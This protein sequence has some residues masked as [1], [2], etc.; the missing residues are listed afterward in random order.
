MIQPKIFCP[1]ETSRDSQKEHLHLECQLQPHRLRVLALALLNLQCCEP[2]ETHSARSH[3]ACDLLITQSKSGILL[4]QNRGR[5]VLRTGRDGTM[6]Q[7]AHYLVESTLATLEAVYVQAETVHWQSSTGEDPPQDWE[8][9][10]QVQRVQAEEVAEIAHALFIHK[11]TTAIAHYR[12]SQSHLGVVLTRG[13]DDLVLIVRENYV[14]NYS[15]TLKDWEF[16]QQI[17]LS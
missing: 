9:H 11:N 4:V 6:M 16:F 12:I 1:L 5:I 7:V 8:L 15:T 2:A 3:Q 17:S 13:D 10:W 14:W